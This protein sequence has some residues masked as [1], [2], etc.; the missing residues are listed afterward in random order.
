MNTPIE[1]TFFFWLIALSASALYGFKAF[2]LHNIK[3]ELKPSD[4]YALGHQ[5]WF[6]FSGAL[7]G[8]LAV[9]ILINDS[10]LCW[11]T[12]CTIDLTLA[13]IILVTTAYIGITGHLPLTF[14]N[15]IEA[16]K[17]ILSKALKW[18]DKAAS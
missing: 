14:M 4:K 13:K 12:V 16:M 11:Y 9:W 18:I 17:Q 5:I 1:F 6:N 7:L 3:K 2:E 8:W 10:W 15:I